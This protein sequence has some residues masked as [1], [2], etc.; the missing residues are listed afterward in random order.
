MVTGS[1]PECPS[2]NVAPPQF[3]FE[4][5]RPPSTSSKHIPT[6]QL[7]KGYHGWKP[8]PTIIGV[9]DPHGPFIAPSPK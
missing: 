9:V 7:N 1:R 6:P 8:Q 3:V 5:N 4:R 2:P